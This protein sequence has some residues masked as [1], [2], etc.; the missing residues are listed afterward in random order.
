[1]CYND[2]FA[3]H[4]NAFLRSV[5]VVTKVL[6]PLW[7][8]GELAFGAT[9]DAKGTKVSADLVATS[10]AAREVAES[11]TSFK[12]ADSGEAINNLLS[13]K[14]SGRYFMIEACFS[15]T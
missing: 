8:E 6:P 2:E 3:M 13:R 12:D 9:F 14:R 10:R 15:A 7:C 5:A 1:M 11:M 4:L